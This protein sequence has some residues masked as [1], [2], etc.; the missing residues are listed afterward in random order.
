MNFNWQEF[1]NENIA[2]HCKT[3]E[4]AKNFIKECYKHGFKWFDASYN[5]DT[6]NWIHKQNTCYEFY[7]SLKYGNLHCFS[8]YKI[9][10]WSNY[11]DKVEGQKEFTKDNLENGMIVELRNGNLG[12]VLNNKICLKDYSLNLDRWDKNLNA[13]KADS[14]KRDI[15]RVY[16]AK[17]SINLLDIVNSNKRIN[18]LELICDLSKRK[19]PAINIKDIPDSELIAELKRRLYIKKKGE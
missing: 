5:S 15:V 19:Q 18:C 11:M 3:E 4:E 13:V 2:V 10:E 6:T 7:Y 1:N 17:N 8:N 12:L 16:A 9:I 14:G